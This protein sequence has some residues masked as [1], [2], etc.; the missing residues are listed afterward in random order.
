MLVLDTLHTTYP[1]C[2]TVCAGAHHNFLV[3]FAGG[4]L[5]RD[6]RHVYGVASS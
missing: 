2:G 1:C 5:A 4:K 3:T 6:A